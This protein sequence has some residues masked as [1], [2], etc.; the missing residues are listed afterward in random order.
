MRH[1]QWLRDTDIDVLPDTWQ[2]PGCMV[3]DYASSD[4]VSCL[5]SRRVVFIG[6]STTRQI[7]HAFAKKLDQSVASEIRQTADQHSNLTLENSGVTVQ[8]LWDP[9]LNSTELTREL[10]LYQAETTQEHT[11]EGS[12]AIVLVGGGLWHARHLAGDAIKSFQLAA[13]NVV[14]Y[15]PPVRVASETRG[16][17]NHSPN[18]L[19]LAPVQTPWYENLSPAREKTIT[20]D[21]I[22]AMNDYLDQLTVKHGSDVPW[23][24]SKMT[25]GRRPTYEESGLHVMDRVAVSR[26]N[27][28]LNLKCN[29]QD[30]LPNGPRYPYNRTCCSDYGT[31]G[32]I[33][34][35]TL[36]CTLGIIPVL[37]WMHRRESPATSDSVIGAIMTFSCAIT[38]CFL[39]DRT[40]MFD[41]QSK[42]VSE[43]TFVNLSVLSLVFGLVSIRHSVS[44]ALSKSGQGCSPA[45]TD[46][47]FLSRD[48]TD[49]WKGWMQFLILAYHYSGASKLLPIYE[50]ARLLVASYLFMTGFGHTLYFYQRQD[51]S[52]R[53]VAAVLVRL[54][55]LSCVLPYIMRT[56]YMFYY[57]APLVTFWFSI[58]YL[59]MKVYHERNDQ[60]L[61]V[62]AKI[63]GSAAL[64]IS[65]TC[66]PGILEAVFTL[67]KYTCR[68]H[69]D[70]REWRFRA[71]LDILIVYVGMLCALVYLKISSASATAR[72]ASD[73]A[74]LLHR[75]M[76]KIKILA[77]IAS[78]V[79]L[80]G[81]FAV[82]R[83][84]PN[85]E[86]YNWWQPIISFLPILSFVVLRNAHQSLRNIYSS[87]FAWLGKCSLETFIL[88]FH[89][90][91]AA[92]TKGLLRLKMFGS[93]II[94]RWLEFSVL[95]LVFLHI[96]WHVAQATTVLT[97]VIVKSPDN[98]PILGQPELQPLRKSNGK[99]LGQD[100]DSIRQGS[101]RRGGLLKVLRQDLRARLG[102]LLFL[103]LTPHRPAQF[104]ASYSLDPETGVYTSAVRSPTG[105]PS[106]PPLTSYGEE[107]SRQLARHLHSLT[108]PIDRVYSSPMYRCLQTLQPSAELARSST[109][110]SSAST[111]WD[112]VRIE[113]GIGEWY[114]AAPFAHPSPAPPSLLHS[115]F[116]FTDKSYIPLT[117]VS[118]HGE[119]IPQLYERVETTLQRIV[120]TLDQE[121]D[122]PRS[123]LICSHAATV[124]A[125]ARILTGRIPDDPGELD[126]QPFTC[127]MFVFKRDE[128]PESE[129][130]SGD[131]EKQSAAVGVLGGW[132]CTVKEDCSFLDGGAERSW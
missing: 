51:Y 55:M 3:H 131:K 15:M 76:T 98:Q 8:F 114:G 69:W 87:G 123:L 49:E 33:Q 111:A 112:V 10:E 121:P 99:T 16:R 18:Y 7:F 2:A 19:L 96:S 62:V 85:K 67:L 4:V 90:W 104:R 64:V 54:N 37:Y 105:I 94:G 58:V 13:D 46:Q 116:S 115:L 50:V 24:F 25:D 11:G 20:P 75:H 118:A 82:T 17:S 70:A 28:L 74:A 117:Q 66:I 92:D 63:L 120:D 21:R 14:S 32:W 43:A 126:F 113:N 65:F 44:S 127:G 83:R 97:H 108:P 101:S 60:M 91:L 72:D 35:T 45:Q 68:I 129:P 81:F 100:L 26:A 110:S 77:I 23:S 1:G 38:L 130:E 42:L 93:G 48:Q 29:A 125:A 84:S 27:V 79:V 30:A 6:D 59:T 57:F 109:T 52:L 5:S 119:T 39:A 128:Q 80:P 56:D 73:T 31:L 34:V 107:Q 106:D 103:M 47:P 40:H 86:D 61:F 102:A 132:E 53:R 71:S 95:T 88:Q 41:K 22:E 36:L 124:I 78:V 12:A 9:Y 89:I 122:Q